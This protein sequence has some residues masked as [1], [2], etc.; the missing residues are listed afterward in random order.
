MRGEEEDSSD[1]TGYGL[2]KHSSFCG[3]RRLSQ[4]EHASWLYKA[5]DIGEQEL[6]LVSKHTCLH[7][8]F[9]VKRYAVDVIGLC[10]KCQ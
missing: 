1:I 2:Q 4:D 6:G 7:G 8:G 9:L 5:T 10:P 3:E